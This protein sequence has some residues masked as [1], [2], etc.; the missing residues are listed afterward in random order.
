VKKFTGKLIF[1]VG[2]TASGKTNVAIQIAKRLNTEVISADS[3]Q[4][5]EEIPI[6]TAAPTSKEQEDV[7]HH[8]VGN[9]SIKDDYNASKF[10]TQ[11]LKLLDSRFYGHQYVVISGGSGLYIN[12][13]FKGIDELPD[14]TE[15]VREKVHGIYESDGINALRKLLEELD[16]EYYNQVDKNNPMRLMR[17]IE[18]CF[19]TGKKY[20]DL[21]KNTNAKR[22]FTSKKI[23]L[24]VERE[25]LFN[26]I[27]SRTHN[28]IA[29][30]WVGEAKKVHSDKQ[31]N[32][33]NTV[34]YKELFAYFE[35]QY[36]MEQAI[37]KIKTNTRR[38]AKR[39]MTW[40]R[41]DESITWFPPSNISAMIDYILE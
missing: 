10:E 32:P 17:A 18:V 21:R 14:A 4:F 6:G 8:F 7:I 30:G 16:P 23:G 3:R 41:K 37:E 38:Y 24:L 19:Q 34:G 1:V 28:M 22:S 40:F 13:V 5:Y 36:T 11:V 31:L 29:D 35:G 9:L 25:A 39:Q 15:K 12:A 27:N 2:P 20:S 26:A 33:L